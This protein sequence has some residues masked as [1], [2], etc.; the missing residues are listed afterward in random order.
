MISHSNMHEKIS[1]FYRV[2]IHCEQGIFSYNELQS[3]APSSST[4]QNWSCQPFSYDFCAD[5]SPIFIRKVSEYCIT[6][7]LHIFKTYI[8]IYTTCTRLLASQAHHFS[9]QVGVYICVFGRIGP[10]H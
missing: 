6:N 2:D 4:R 3:V 7:A 5:V 8:D 9:G 1:L 10:L